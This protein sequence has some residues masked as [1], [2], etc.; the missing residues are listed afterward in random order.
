MFFSFLTKFESNKIIFNLSS[1]S[2]EVI[3]TPLTVAIILYKLSFAKD[4]KVHK[5]FIN[6]MDNIILFD[7]NL[8]TTSPC[9]V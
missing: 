4:L 1:R 8:I 2:N 3:G 5:K 7:D 9:D 6:K